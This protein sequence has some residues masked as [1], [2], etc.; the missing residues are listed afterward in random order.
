MK[1]HTG[2]LV[3]PTPLKILPINHKNQS[4]VENE[5]NYSERVSLVPPKMV[6][7]GT[8]QAMPLGQP[9]LRVLPFTRH[10]VE[11]RNQKSRC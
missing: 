4:G 6:E 10:R 3:G 5:E 9:R 1:N 8:A 2:L 7:D 11:S